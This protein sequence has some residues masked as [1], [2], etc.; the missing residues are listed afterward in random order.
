[1]RKAYCKADGQLSNPPYKHGEDQRILANKAAEPTCEIWTYRRP[2]LTRQAAFTAI[3]AE[4][5][6]CMQKTHRSFYFDLMETLSQAL[7][8]ETEDERSDMG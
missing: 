3:L 6:S 5:V 2:R 1:M 8:V 7:S 4:A